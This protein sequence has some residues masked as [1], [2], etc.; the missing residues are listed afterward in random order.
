[1]KRHFKKAGSECT[2]SEQH[3][4]STTAFLLDLITVLFTDVSSMLNVNLDR[5]I[6]TIHTRVASEGISFLTKTLPQF[7][8][9]VLSSLRVGVFTPP[10]DFPFKR[11]RRGG[12]HPAFLQDILCLVFDTEG[13]ELTE[14]STEAL[15]AIS[16]ICFLFYKYELGY[17]SDSAQQLY[18]DNIRVDREYATLDS[19]LLDK[20]HKKGNPIQR[21]AA[22]AS[23]LIGIVMES[24]DTEKVVPSHGPGAVA[25]SGVK[26]HEKF[27]FRG[28]FHPKLESVFRRET[29]TRV[30]TLSDCESVA[31]RSP[32]P[33]MD[34]RE[35]DSSRGLVARVNSFSFLPVSKATAVPKDSRG[36]RGISMEP[37]EHMWFQQGIW[38]QMK[39]I[40]ESH[41]L[42]AGHVNFSDQTINGDLALKASKDGQMA[43]LDL[44]EASDRVS[45]N[46]V[47]LLFPERLFRDLDCTRSTHTDF[48]LKPETLRLCLRKFAPM[49]SA[50]CFPT[51]ALIFWA[52]CVGTLVDRLNWD[53]LKAAGAVFVYGDDIIVPTEYAET[54]IEALEA[55]NLRVNTQKSYFSGWFR[56]SCGVDAYHGEVVTPVKVKTIFPQE[57][58]DVAG[59]VAW[60]DYGNHFHKI[61]YWHT[62]NHIKRLVHDIM[63]HSLPI[64]PENFGAV[65]W[66][67]FCGEIDSTDKWRPILQCAKQGDVKYVGETFLWLKRPNENLGPMARVRRCP[68]AESQTYVPSK[69]AFPEE[70]AYLRW[71]TS[72]HPKNSWVSSLFGSGVSSSRIFSLR[73]NL[74]WKYRLCYYT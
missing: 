6:E 39:E 73:D 35:N 12:V 64:V 40:L 25:Q 57:R 44:K 66:F 68:V 13:Y 32:R 4:D 58:K 28:E 5:D 52:I 50:V 3:V 43:T 70:A 21:I 15:A 16:Q 63:G 61:G 2:G 49:G 47:R 26:P 48:P 69:K 51:E 10:S 55:F 23:N 56:E 24:Y 7:G 1:M 20:V 8:K 65:G 19:S 54:I 22:H 36:P 18:R 53:Y 72:K 11:A 59:V 30:P 42:T 31:L 27:Q 41:P 71:L 45:Y 37:I 33:P 14:P 34:P 17:A 60:V 9:T 67:S 29:W 38:R 74:T 46:L 62:A